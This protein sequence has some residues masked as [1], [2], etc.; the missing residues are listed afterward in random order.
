MQK[1]HIIGPSLYSGV[2]DGGY[3]TINLFTHWTLALYQP[4]Q[5]HLWTI[6][7]VVLSIQKHQQ[8]IFCNEDVARDHIRTALMDM[9][10][11]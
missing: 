5:Q 1:K 10:F 2:L 4:V 7:V 3:L 6:A 8:E 9:Y 11:I